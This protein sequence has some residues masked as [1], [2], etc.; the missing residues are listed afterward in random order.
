MG[1]VCEKNHELWV[2]DIQKMILVGRHGQ[3]FCN[4]LRVVHYSIHF[5]TFQDYSILFT[6]VHFSESKLMDVNLS[7]NA[8]Q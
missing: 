7:R 8:D 4:N 3:K 6:I 2:G 1:L 5:N